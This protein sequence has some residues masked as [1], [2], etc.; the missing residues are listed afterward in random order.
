LSEL[1]PQFP[2]QV[3]FQL[4]PHE[5]DILIRGQIL[6]DLR[7]AFPAVRSHGKTIGLSPTPGDL[8]SRPHHLLV[9]TGPEDGRTTPARDISLQRRPFLQTLPVISKARVVP[10]TATAQTHEQHRHPP[11]G[12]VT[13]AAP[14]H[15][16]GTIHLAISLD[17]LEENRRE[18]RNGLHGDVALHGDN[19]RDAC[20]CQLWTQAR[21]GAIILRGRIFAR[22]G[23][24]TG[25]EN[26]QPGPVL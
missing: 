10:D 19:G 1:A 3:I 26:N 18:V 14:G 13:Y 15:G 5:R 9:Q 4:V 8:S 24:L 6:S 16:N 12:A 22:A 25:N 20:L 21:Q 17:L 2:A 11:I 23:T 7:Q